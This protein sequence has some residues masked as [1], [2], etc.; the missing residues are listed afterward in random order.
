MMERLIDAMCSNV[1]TSMFIIL[2]NNDLRLLKFNISKINEELARNKHRANQTKIGLMK[3]TEE[4]K[5]LVES[6]TNTYEIQKEG[7]DIQSISEELAKV[8]SIVMQEKKYLSHLPS[9]QDE[10]Q[11]FEDVKN[12]HNLLLSQVEAKNFEIQPLRDAIKKAQHHQEKLRNDQLLMNKR[13]QLDEMSRRLAQSQSSLL[14]FSRNGVQRHDISMINA[15]NSFNRVPN[16]NG[17]TVKEFKKSQDT[18]F[19]DNNHKYYQQLPMHNFNNNLT[20]DDN[21]NRNDV[22]KK[23]LSNQSTLLKT[24][25]SKSSLKYVETIPLVSSSL[26]TSSDSFNAS[27]YPT[28]NDLRNTKLSEEQSRLK[29][30]F[31]T[32]KSSLEDDLEIIEFD[33]DI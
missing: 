32:A 13:T 21:T 29:E 25:H 19:N 20:Y 22:N 16:Q 10:V 17:D 5:G 33:G 7:L 1:R 2:L 28:K 3:H 23:I 18:M 26:Y 31:V 8:K 9:L 6:L 12:R 24:H 30:N 14:Q 4:M 15:T 11:N 27:F